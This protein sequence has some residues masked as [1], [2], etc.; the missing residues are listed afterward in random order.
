[1][2]KPLHDHVVLKKSYPEK[3]NKKWDYFN[4]S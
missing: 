4:D 3:K 2:L 1:M